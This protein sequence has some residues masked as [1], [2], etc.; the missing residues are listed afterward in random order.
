LSERRFVVE[1]THPVP[2]AEVAGVAALVAERLDMDPQRIVTL[3]SG[4]VGAVTKAVLP[5]KAIAIAD[6]FSAA[7][8]EVAVL[9][10]KT[11]DAPRAAEREDRPPPEPPRAPR[12]QT[13]VQQEPEFRPE[14]ASRAEPSRPAPAP[15]QEPDPAP[16]PA[17]PAD[18]WPDVAPQDVHTDASTHDFA[19]QE[20]PEDRATGWVATQGWEVDP[21]VG[22]WRTSAA[23]E[24]A[25]LG[26]AAEADPYGEPPGGSADHGHG[27]GREDGPTA[28]SAAAGDWGERYGERPGASGEGEPPYREPAALEE[29]DP[30]GN[31][32]PAAAY[33]WLDEQGAELE[34]EADRLGPRPSEAGPSTFSTST[35]WVPSPHD[36]YGF[37]PEEVPLVPTDGPTTAAW[38]DTHGWSAGRG[39]PRG[40]HGSDLGHLAAEPPR[41]GPRLRVFLMWGLIVS[42]AVFLLLQFVMADRAHS[43]AGATAFAVGLAAFRNG[44]FVAALRAWEPEAEYGDPDAQY[45]L[46]YMAQNGLG[47]PWSNARAAGYYRRAAEAGHVEAQL[48]LGDLYLRGMGVELDDA[49]GAGLVAR[50]AATGDPKGRFEYGKLLL[51]GRGVTRDPVAALAEFEAAAAGGLAVAADYVAFAREA[52]VATEVAPAAP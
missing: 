44:D 51:H 29:E 3:L 27:A 2:E 25:Q 10:A 1:I 13:V 26:E 36:E 34:A 45:Y 52:V 42:I 20:A 17:A 8:V 6:V 50:A 23:P 47:Q 15:R 28:T 33:G 19:Y 40:G 30:G 22:L 5:D 37:D 41:E 46:G 18:E 24:D 4:R 14:P 9:P 49:K 11:Q 21:G 12:A 43:G 38:E 7:G 32:V 48:A 35:R 16:P 31:T 39:A